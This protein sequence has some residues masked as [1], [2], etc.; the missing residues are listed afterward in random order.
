MPDAPE[1]PEPFRVEPDPAEGPSIGAGASG[2]S[3]YEPPTPPP[4]LSPVPSQATE[5]VGEDLP[6]G[7]PPLPG[8]PP[9]PGDPYG[10]PSAGGTGG[11]YGGPPPGTS[12]GA[13]PYTPSAPPSGGSPYEAPPAGGPYSSA[14]PGSPQA[15]WPGGPTYPGGP[16][17][18]PAPPPD[19]RV[20]AGRGGG[21]GTAALV[22]GV[23]S[24]FLLFACGLGTLTAV[25]GLIVGFVAVAKDSNRGRAWVGIGLSVLTLIAAA[26]FVA[27]FFSRAGV[28]MDLPPGARERCLEER[29]GVRFD[30]P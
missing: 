12:G 17:R 24:L 4:G 1:V 10:G 22:F 25:V 9:A 21:I 30:V 16:A 28:C 3:R 2:P 20:T 5:P 7:T 27:W 8:R 18:Y 6:P 13:H 11:P 19:V 14:P 29:F 15:S 23:V 26:A